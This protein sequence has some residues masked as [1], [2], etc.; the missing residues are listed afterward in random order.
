MGVKPLPTQL[1]TLIVPV[2]LAMSL[3]G[4]GIH[5]G[6]VPNELHFVKATLK[7]APQPKE[8]QISSGDQLDIK[9][10]YHP[11]LNE[12]LP[13]RPDGKIS[14]RLIGDVQAAG[15]EPSALATEL[16]Q[17][18]ARD[19]RD[20]EI[21]VIVKTF[22]AQQIFVDG[23]VERPGQL[24]LPPGLT[25]WQAVI[26]AGGFKNTATRESVIL[27]RRGDHDQPIPYRINL[28]PDYL[29]QT[30]AAMQL[31]PYDVV[32]VPKTWIA[33]ADKFTQQYVQ[34]LL[35]FKG[36]Y[37]NINPIEPIINTPN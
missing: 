1:T 25:V 14:L 28:K 18:Y 21:T 6:G 24:E 2:V 22:S 7:P 13:V 26:K 30:S 9:F 12:S 34:D 3:A 35:L 16:R 17:R 23:E 5:Q 27:I 20:P 10:F 15:L 37:F 4:C 32:F 36:W 29:E 33:E 31:Q 11:E 19:L 8:Y